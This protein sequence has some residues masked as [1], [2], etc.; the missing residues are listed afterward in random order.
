MALIKLENYTAKG[1]QFYKALFSAD[2]HEAQSIYFNI[3]RGD[4][5]GVKIDGHDYVII[6]SLFCEKRGFELIIRRKP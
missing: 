6:S 3:K 1:K 5:M 2:D 4:K